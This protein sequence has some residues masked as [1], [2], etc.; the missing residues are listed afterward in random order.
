MYMPS[1]SNSIARGQ[2]GTGVHVT[3]VTRARNSF[4]ITNLGQKLISMVRQFQNMI[5]TIL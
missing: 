2:L 1:L 4:M 3:D 5:I